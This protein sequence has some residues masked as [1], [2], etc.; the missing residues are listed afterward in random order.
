M[1]LCMSDSSVSFHGK[2][3]FP[4]QLSGD[5]Y[6]RK[7][8]SNNSFTL[9]QSSK[10]IHKQRGKELAVSAMKIHKKVEDCRIGR[11]PGFPLFFNIR[12]EAFC[13]FLV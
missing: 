2:F 5:L 13:C 4:D 1:L 8:V 12:D 7:G 11:E 6:Y 3:D 9:S 10:K